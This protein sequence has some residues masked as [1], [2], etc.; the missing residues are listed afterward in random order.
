MSALWGAFRYEFRMQVTRPA[1]WLV[2]LGVGLMV[3]SRPWERGITRPAF[4][5]VGDWAMRLGIILPLG[6]GLMLADRLARDRR[7]RVSEL[8]ESQPSGGSSRLLGKYLGSVAASALPILLQYLYGVAVIM[9][10]WHAGP[11]LLLQSLLLFAV[12]LLPGLLFVAAFSL[13]CPTFMPVPLYQ[14]LFVGY[15]FWGNAL[16]PKTGIPTLTG[17]PLMPS[18]SYIATGIFGFAGSGAVQ[19]ATRPL[20]FVSL[21]LLVAGAAGAL[22]LT[23][24]ILHLQAEQG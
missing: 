12:I 15:W 1:M 17:T 8:L 7:L 18:G 14:V 10:H 4:E 24:R 9:A 20:G 5:A 22:A 11:V 21:A 23:R 3:G 13:G 2:Q 19:H 16:S 6:F